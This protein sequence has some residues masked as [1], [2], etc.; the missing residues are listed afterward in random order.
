MK[1]VEASEKVAINAK[2]CGLVYYKLFNEHFRALWNKKQDSFL[3]ISTAE[4]QVLQII[5][6]MFGYTEFVSENSITDVNVDNISDPKQ[7]YES[8]EQLYTRIKDVLYSNDIEKMAEQQRM[9]KIHDQDDDMTARPKNKMT[10]NK[11]LQ[12]ELCTLINACDDDELTAVYNVVSM[13][14]D[15][16]EKYASS[17]VVLIDQQIKL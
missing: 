11:I 16:Y 14:I 6:N 8:E 10:Q 1:L 9:L 15:A 7:F 2:K 5:D 17:I 4:L 12:T 3:Q 13:Y